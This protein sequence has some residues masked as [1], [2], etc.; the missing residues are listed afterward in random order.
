MKRRYRLGIIVGIWG[1]ISACGGKADLG[2]PGEGGQDAEAWP[3]ASS[4]ATVDASDANGDA[5]DGVADAS[6]DASDD[7]TDARSGVADAGADASIDAADAA[8]DAALLLPPDA[9]CN[10]AA[11]FG[12]P[13]P[14]ALS[15]GGGDNFDARLTLDELTVYFASD[16]T[17]G[18]AAGLRIYSATRAHSTDS[19][20]PAAL[21][22]GINPGGV[23]SEYAPSVTEDGLS[24]YMNQY[25]PTQT[26]HVIFVST[27]ASRSLPFGAPALLSSVVL[28]GYSEANPIVTPDGS[29]LYFFV[30]DGSGGSPHLYSS[31]R[32][33][34]GTLSTPTL[35]TELAA[36]NAGNLAVSADQLTILFSTTR[37]DPAGANWDIWVSHRANIA[38]PWGSPTSLPANVNSAGADAPTW[39]SGDGCRLYLQSNRSGGR[40]GLYLA[41]RPR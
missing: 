11:P 30:Q 39:I 33:T 6:S 12:D 4:D 37:G 38:D 29:A 14:L 23:A 10:P 41:T 28:P 7:V 1:S 26:P 21:V 20:G 13:V 18:D 19:F 9:S 32:D 8:S 2:P 31:S 16:S 3:E 36:G 22:D 34:S 5:S 35:I 24:F 17:P 40:Y 25:E 27:R 15:G